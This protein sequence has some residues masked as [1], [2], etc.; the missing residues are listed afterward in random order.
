MESSEIQLRGQALLA[1]PLFSTHSQMSSSPLNN[2]SSLRGKGEKK[3][4]SKTLML[5][6]L[7][8]PSLFEH[9]C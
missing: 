2:K 7:I 5:T 9:K 4:N 1:S 6:F 8:I 3:K